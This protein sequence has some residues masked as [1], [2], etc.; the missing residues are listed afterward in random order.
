MLEVCAAVDT[1]SGTIPLVAP[2]ASPGK[3]AVLETVAGGQAGSPATLMDMRQPVPVVEHGPTKGVP[4]VS[5]ELLPT[6]KKIQ[7]SVEVGVPLTNSVIGE[8]ALLFAVTK[9]V[10]GVPTPV[11]TAVAGAKLS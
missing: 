3:V 2:A 7:S 4:A 6:L 10:R 8:H 9:P 11:S 1:L 5:F